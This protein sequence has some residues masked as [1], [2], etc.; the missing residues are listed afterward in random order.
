MWRGEA[1]GVQPSA[2]LVSR[3]SVGPRSG[4]PPL[5]VRS[6]VGLTEFFEHRSVAKLYLNSPEWYAAQEEGKFAVLD[7]SRASS[8]QLGR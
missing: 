8:V 7:V 3:S 2:Y 4:V 6:Q 1:S 5:T